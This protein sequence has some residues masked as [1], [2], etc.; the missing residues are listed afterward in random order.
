MRNAL[1]LLGAGIFL[2]A[3][4]VLRVWWDSPLYCIHFGWFCP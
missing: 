1:L 3:T 2:L 4:I